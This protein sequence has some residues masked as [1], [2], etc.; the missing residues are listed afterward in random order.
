MITFNPTMTIEEATK[1]YNSKTGMNYPDTEHN[2]R[3]MR[4]VIHN[5]LK[6]MKNS[7]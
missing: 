7:K 6:M 1:L 2:R 3:V 4:E 5:H